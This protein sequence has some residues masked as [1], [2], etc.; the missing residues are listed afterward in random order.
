MARKSKM[1]QEIISRKI[2]TLRGE[3]FKGKQATA[4]ALR[5]FRDGELPRP[6]SKPRPPKRLQN[7][8]VNRTNR[9]NR[10][11]RR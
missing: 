6:R 2:R 7:R 8:L 3:G 1:Q 11:N 5:M 10:T 4:I 9:T